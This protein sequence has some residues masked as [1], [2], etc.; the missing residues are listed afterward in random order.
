[1]NEVKLLTFATPLVVLLQGLPSIKNN[2]LAVRD[3]SRRSFSCLVYKVEDLSSTGEDFPVLNFMGVPQGCFGYLMNRAAIKVA[4]EN[5]S[6]I[7]SVADWPFSW[8]RRVRFVASY[9]QLVGVDLTDSILD[10]NRKIHTI[11]LRSDLLSSH[12]SSVK[13]RM[14]TLIGLLGIYSFGSLMKGLG[15]YTHYLENVIYPL[16]VRRLN[17]GKHLKSD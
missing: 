2:S 7:D 11:K 15:F 1:M 8:R 12:E 10:E 6:V 16:I 17:N 13:A 4:C 3:Q 14:R 5:Q 9:K